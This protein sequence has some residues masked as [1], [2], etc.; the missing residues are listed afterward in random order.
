MGVAVH[1]ADNSDVQ[2]TCCDLYGNAGG[3]W[4]GSVAAQAG[5]NG[6]ICEDPLFC[7]PAAGNFRLQPDS[8]CGPFT[9][10][11]PEC[12]LVGAHPVGCSSGVPG[13]NIAAG[14]VRWYP[15]VPNPFQGH[16]RIEFETSMD[17]ADARISIHDAAGRLVRRLYGA[18]LATGRYGV[19]WDGHDIFG[20]PVPAGVYYGRL[21]TAGA[22]QGQAM[23][24]LR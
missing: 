24:V 17:L 10:P 9:A 1:A 13:V 6:N 18:P 19:V 23:L 15:A 2:L 4:V 11:N 20:R 21:S 22:V 16:T 7:A 8:P 5:I 3:D 14:G 12:D